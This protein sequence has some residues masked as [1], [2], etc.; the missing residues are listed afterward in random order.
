[1][2]RNSG[3]S[4]ERS[5]MEKLL[6]E[7]QGHPLAWAFLQPVNGEEVADYYDVIKQPMGQFSV[8]RG[9]CC[10][11][12]YELNVPHYRLCNNGTQT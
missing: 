7:L 12:S 8:D 11:D 4:A 2:I 9:F 1:M 10:L 5:A 6:S 3:K